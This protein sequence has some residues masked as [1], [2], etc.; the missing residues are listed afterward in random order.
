MVERA[1]AALSETAQTFGQQGHLR[2]AA[3]SDG[4][5]EAMVR[6]VIAALRE[7]TG[8]V[9]NAGIAS[10]GRDDDRSSPEVWLDCWLAGIDAALAED[11]TPD[12]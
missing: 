2:A 6:A 9:M 4:Y 5:A 12:G 1:K 11:G 3:P 7:P 10:F 8:A